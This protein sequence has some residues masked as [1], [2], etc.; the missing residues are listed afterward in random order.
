VS[1]LIG[2]AGTLAYIVLGLVAY[3]AWY[4]TGPEEYEWRLYAQE[5]AIL[6]TWPV[7]IPVSIGRKYV[8]AYQDMR[9][10]RRLAERM[11][12]RIRL[13]VKETE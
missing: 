11:Q 2:A 7:S 5:C 4:L 3:R 12:E 8:W 6:L 9:D 13:N 1:Y 10:A